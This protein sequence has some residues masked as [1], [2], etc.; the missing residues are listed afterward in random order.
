MS[1]TLLITGGAGFIGSALIRYLLRES[2]YRIV[3]VDKLTYAA[4][5][6]S[7]EDAPQNPRYAFERVDICD[8]SALERV[9]REHRPDGVIHLAAESHVD[10]SIDGPADFMQTNIIGTF[11]LLEASLAYWQQLG[12]DARAAFRFHHVSTDEVY[13]SLGDTGYFTETTPYAPNSPYSAS[14]ASSDLLVRAWHHT[15]G[16]PVVTSNCSNN[17]GP[18]QFPEKLIPLMILNALEGKPLPVY[19]TGTNVRDWLFVDDHARALRD[20]FER[21][22]IGEQYNI[23]G[24]NEKRNIDLV[25]E[26]CTLLDE[27]LPQS[28]HR[29]HDRLITFVEDRRGH[30]RRYAIDA[31]K[32]QRE[33]GWKPRETFQTG[34]RK[35]VQWYLNNRDWCRAIQARGY[36]GERLG[37]ARRVS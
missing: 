9:F 27:M 11:H 5:L 23:G 8:A 1:K 14:K 10:R 13:G 18:Y 4:S 15:Y 36:R 16:L 2:D 21:G 7:L 22:R 31:S 30:D 28:P 17:Y 26:L 25:R 29:P 6:E 19:G 12:A 35:T 3:N 32:I 34:L 33:L 20:V 24:H 37:L